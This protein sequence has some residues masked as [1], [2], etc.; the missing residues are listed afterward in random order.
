MASPS[1]GLGLVLLILLILLLTGHS[2]GEGH[3][4]K[5]I[6]YGDAS[7]QGILR[8]VNSLAGCSR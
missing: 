4:A 3:M 8:G 1:G 5:R 2:D 6:V 7:R